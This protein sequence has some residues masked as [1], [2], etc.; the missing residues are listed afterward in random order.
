MTIALKVWNSPR[1]ESDVRVYVS[2]FREYA[3]QSEFAYADGA[4]FKADE[5]GM[6][7]VGGFKTS[8]SGNYGRSAHA[9]RDAFQ[10]EGLPFSEFL[11][12]IANAQTKGGNFSEVQYFKNLRPVAA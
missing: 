3:S 4:W 8:Y 9:V 12:R 11:N 1:N 6:T 2:T 10:L 5:N 7:V